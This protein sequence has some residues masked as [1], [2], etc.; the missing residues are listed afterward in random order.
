LFQG[1]IS[2]LFPGIDVPYVD[3]GHLQSA[4]EKTLDTLSL[5]KVPTF[6]TKCIQVHETQLVRHGMMVVGETAS[7]K[8]TNVKVLSEALTMLYENKIVD[9]DGFYKPV[10]C[11][12][13]NPKSITAGELY[14]EFNLMTNEWKDGIVPK[15]VRDC[16]NALNE[17]SIN[18]K[19]IIFDGPVDAVWIENMNTV[20]DDNKTLCLANSER[21]KLPSTLHMLFEV[22]DLKVASPAT[23]SRCGMVFM[24]Q[25]HVGMMSL[26]QTWASLHLK[27]IAGLKV[28]KQLVST[29][30]QYLGKCIEFIRLECKEK[31]A[32]TN[33]QISQN[34]LNIFLA[35][36]NTDADPKAVTEDGDLLHALLV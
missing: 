9:R 4:I 11:L 24:E 29:I 21:I 35:K 6:I 31:V 1:I 27:P 18:R 16:V 14:G 12:I 20:L 8:S 30:D 36:L 10:D 33:N 32:T 7:G 15:L 3:Y 23:V 26:V 17:G 2:D 13:L 5:Q 22:Q 28:A 25:I 19:W 34:L